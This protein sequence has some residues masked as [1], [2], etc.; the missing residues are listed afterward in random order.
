MSGRLSAVLPKAQQATP[1]KNGRQG[2]DKRM[3][4]VGMQHHCQEK[5]ALTA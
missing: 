4:A 5:D 3:K 2:A 1:S